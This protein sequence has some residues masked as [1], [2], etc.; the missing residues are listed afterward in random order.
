LHRALGI[1]GSARAST[2]LYTTEEVFFIFLI[3]RFIY[4][5]ADSARAITYF[6]STEEV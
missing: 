4:G 3:H 2:Y 1:A 5:A 6:Y